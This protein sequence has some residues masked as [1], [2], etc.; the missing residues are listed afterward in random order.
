MPLPS[1]LTN[2][3]IR[4]ACRSWRFDH[5]GKNASQTRVG[6]GIIRLLRLPVPPH[7]A[8]RLFPLVAGTIAGLAHRADAV[9]GHLWLASG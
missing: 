5:P 8:R 9:C 6:L 2:S 4:S 1:L 7:A 3:A